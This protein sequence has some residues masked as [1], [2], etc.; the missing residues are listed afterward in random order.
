MLER[1]RRAVGAVQYT[2]IAGIRLLA[3]D[4]FPQNSKTVRQIIWDLGGEI[5]REYSV[6]SIEVINALKT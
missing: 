2:G 5:A 4:S 3:A 6:C 1:S